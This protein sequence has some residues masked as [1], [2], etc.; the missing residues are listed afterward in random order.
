MPGVKIGNGHYCRA[1]CGDANISPFTVAG[2][3]PARVMKQCFDSELMA[4]LQA[5]RWWDLPE[6]G[7]TDILPVLCEA[8][9]S[10]AKRQLSAQAGRAARS[11]AAMTKSPAAAAWPA[12]GLCRF[13]LKC[14]DM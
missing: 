5:L 12:A 9:P 7:L 13:A 6:L 4:I 1:Q 2:G 3:N 10:L 14:S 11:T 8:G